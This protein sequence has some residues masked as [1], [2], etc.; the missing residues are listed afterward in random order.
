[1]SKRGFWRFVFSMDAI[2]A[3]LLFLTLIGVLSYSLW[4]GEAQPDYAWGLLFGVVAYPV[5]LGLMWWQKRS[6][7]EFIEQH[8]EESQSAPEKLRQRRR[9]WR[10][11]SLVFF[12]AVSLFLIYEGHR[13]LL[14]NF[15]PAQYLGYVFIGVAVLGMAGVNIWYGGPLDPRLDPE[16]ETDSADS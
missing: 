14:I 2:E 15:L 6:D 9:N 5:V 13:G 4:A 10:K 3:H 16:E 12:A 1:M 7:Q 11:G 8:L